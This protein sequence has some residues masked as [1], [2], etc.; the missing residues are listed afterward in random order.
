MRGAARV[1]EGAAGLSARV[2]IALCLAALAFAGCRRPA[3]EPSA[4]LR[5]AWL[6]EP[7]LRQGFELREGGGLA[8]L[9]W[10]DRSG[11]AWSA[12]HGE[13]VL[14][15]ND[16]RN[17]E[18]HVARLRVAALE[19]GMLE[20][21]GKDEPFAGVYRPAKVSHVRGVVTYRE[22][23]ALGPDA[24]VVIALTRPGGAAVA[25]QTF[26]PRAQV[27]IGFDLSVP[28]GSPGEL[29][30]HARLADREL[31]LFATQ[32]PVRVTPG[33]EPLQIL[34]RSAR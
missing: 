15:T 27:P 28:A 33:G 19:P 25:L 29:E 30:L 5:G 6:R 26:L 10:G 9:G 20:L 14:S 17:V 8:L 7:E 2:T 18:S 11:L 34:L 21:E 3:P 4:E 12:S 1:R 13:L 22:R 16:E 32:E 24:R 31:T 23:L